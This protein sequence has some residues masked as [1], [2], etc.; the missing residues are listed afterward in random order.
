MPYMAPKKW[1]R[2][3]QAQQCQ[4]QLCHTRM[5]HYSDPA[6]T[7]SCN[8][9]LDELDMDEYYLIYIYIYMGLW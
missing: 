4:T 7:E 5:D 3:V 8:M 2:M 6:G 9:Q 1:F